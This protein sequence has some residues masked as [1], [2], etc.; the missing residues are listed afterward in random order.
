MNK[1]ITL[2]S[3][4][5]LASCTTPKQM[6]TSL[7]FN[8]KTSDTYNYYDK[9]SKISYQLFNDDENLY[10]NLK[11]FDRMSIVKILKSGLTIHFD[12]TGKKKETVAIEYPLHNKNF[13]FKQLHP[14]NGNNE[15]SNFDVN[16]LI[17]SVPNSAFFINNKNRQSFNLELN[18]TD[19]SVKLEAIKTELE[20]GLTYKLKIPLREITEKPMTSIENFS[21]GIITGEIKS[22]Q[23]QSS[24]RPSGGGRPAGVGGG[25]PSGGGVGRPSSGGRPSNIPNDVSKIT[26]P[27]EIWF[28]LG[29]E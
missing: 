21:I 9:D 17:Q 8:E 3:I 12:E 15:S 13:D 7:P 2:L 4:V 26:K 19:V 22:P 14:Q 10:L 27:I 6:V 28:D 23:A 24:G 16:Q 1:I 25:R 20:D 29:V 5:L 18:S 11:T